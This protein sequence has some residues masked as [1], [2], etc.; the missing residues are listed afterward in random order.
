[1]SRVRRNIRSLCSLATIAAITVGA[2]WLTYFVYRSPRRTD[3]SIFGSFVD[4]LAVLAVGM[5]VRVWRNGRSSA[6]QPQRLG[7]LA[8]DLAAAVEEQW[9][10]VAIHDGLLTDA[11]PVQWGKAA[12]GI[13]GPPSAAL[14]SKRFAPLPGLQAVTA[15]DLESGLVTDFYAVYGG[16]GSGRLVIAGDRGSG[17]STAAV[18]LIRA[19]LRH[20]REHSDAAD[21]IPV[22]VLF[23]V[24]SWNPDTQRIQDWIA[25]QLR[26]TYP[27]LTGRSGA[28]KAVRLLDAGRLAV[29]LDDFDGIPDDLRPLALRALSQQ[30]EFRVVVLT[31]TDKMV[32]AAGLDG[33]LAGA[34]AVELQGVVPLSA[35]EYLLNAQ[36]DPTPVHWSDLAERLLSAQGGPI[37]QALSNPLNLG[38]IRDTYRNEEAIGEFLDYCE[39]PGRRSEQISEYLLDQVVPSAYRRHPGDPP[40]R[41]RQETAEHVLCCLAF[42]MNQDELAWWSVR[43]WVP[44]APRGIATGLAFGVAAGIAAGLAGGIALG[45]SLGLTAMFTFGLLFGFSPLPVSTAAPRTL[46]HVISRSSMIR[47]L[48]T[49]LACGACLGLAVGVAVALSARPAA[50]LTA[51][52]TFGFAGA[53]AGEGY[54]VLSRAGVEMARSLTPTKSWRSNRWIGLA[55]G[56]MGGVAGGLAFGI[57]FGLAGGF[58][59]GL[60][61]GLGAALAVERTLSHTKH[62]PTRYL[63]AVVTGAGVGLAVGLTTGAPPGLSFGLVAGLCGGLLLGLLAGLMT[64]RT[65]WA[66]LAF[67]QLALAEH[68]PLR[69][70]RFLEDACDRKVLRT[71]GPEYQ[72]RHARLRERLAERER[73]ARRAEALR[74]EGEM[75]GQT[76]A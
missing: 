28:R 46:R 40:L 45:V 7:Q 3:L 55:V 2:V 5:C 49:A 38:L 33:P 43:D 31:R 73:T 66:T 4:A 48:P 22:P 36:L 32:E 50:G 58:A 69:L 21:R 23:S 65:W 47:A 8:D 15:S 19:A 20:R 12:Q 39:A 35:A 30:A 60:V 1:M 16:L 41:Y 63:A 56:L 11:I 53:L 75:R 37:A 59:T 13:A 74:C 71:V 10:R 25:G 76:V 29:I 6:E 57:A 62:W 67:G 34:V 52:L 51:G 70:T 42:H 27:L 26:Q 64:T 44:A 68:I 72:F 61:S 14:R 9:Q 17:K 24:A 54:G 18:L